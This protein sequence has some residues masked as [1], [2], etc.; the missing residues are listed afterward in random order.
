V[1]GLALR[2]DLRKTDPANGVFRDANNQGK[3]TP[4]VQ[5]WAIF[6]GGVSISSNDFPKSVAPVA[7]L[8]QGGDDNDY[9][10]AI[11]IDPRRTHP[12]TSAQPEEFV[13]GHM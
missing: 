2:A 1:E 5:G 13:P 9:F 7:I 11:T 3:T 8:R 12:L 6:D 4:W 10:F